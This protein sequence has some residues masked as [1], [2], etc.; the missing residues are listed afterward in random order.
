MRVRRRKTLFVAAVCGG[1]ILFAGC[2][3][4]EKPDLLPRTTQA[5]EYFVA[6]EMQKAIEA[7]EAAQQKYPNEKPILEEFIVALEKM[8]SQAKRDYDAGEYAAAE[9][10]CR[11]LLANFSRFA[12][13][14]ESLS[15]TR[16]A[17]RERILGCRINLSQRLARQSLEAGDFQKAL[18]AYLVY[19]NE[20]PSAAALGA[21]FIGTAEE[22]KRIADQ[23]QARKDFVTAGKGY[24]VLRK[25]YPPAQMTT[26]LS[27]SKDVLDEGLVRCRT[28]LTRQGL[29]QYRKGNLKEAIETWKGLLEFDPE[30]AE[31]KRAM[32]TAA[33]QLKKLKKE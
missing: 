21:G 22:V 6:G 8:N 32:E 7:Y 17:L 24:A 3:A 12:G 28:E 27:F 29:N 26:P 15:F 31:I 33:E 13:F 25:N 30:N 14:E 9:K 2:A 5:R 4:R 11:L 1:L 16:P 20:T 23:A 19:L 18:D 10:A